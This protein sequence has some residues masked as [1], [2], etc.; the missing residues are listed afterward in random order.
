MSNPKHQRSV[1]LDAEN[2]QRVQ[3]L[4]DEKMISISAIIRML[5]TA[6]WRQKNGSAQTATD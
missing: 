3:A 4:A 1:N 6:E 2:Y 5:I